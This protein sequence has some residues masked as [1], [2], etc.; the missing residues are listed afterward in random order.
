[1]RGGVAALPADDQI[2]LQCRH[3]FHIEARIA[4]DARDLLRCLRVVAVVDRADDAVAGTGG[5]Q[6]LGHVRR[7]A[8]DALRRLR[9]LH[10]CCRC[11]P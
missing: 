4:A 8:D 3:G 6:R 7:E 10:P 5:E 9:E 1:M 11:R 2:R